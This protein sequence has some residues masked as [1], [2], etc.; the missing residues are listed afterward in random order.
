MDDSTR[1]TYFEHY[2]PLKFGSALF[3]KL[4][5]KHKKYWKLPHVAG[6]P[7]VFAVQD[8]HA[9]QAMSWSSSSLVEYLY[10]IRQVEKRRDDGSSEIVSEPIESY[11]KD[12]GREIPA[13]FFLQPDAE[14]ISAILANPEGTISKFNRMGFLAGFG[15]LGIRM[16]RNGT[17]YRDSLIPQDFAH[18]VHSPEYFE[19]WCEGL[20][21]YHNPRANYPLSPDSIPGAAHHF[22]RDGRILSRLPQFHP[23]GSLTAIVPPTKP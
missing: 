17:C 5:R 9:P 21:V 20:S 6:Y 8:F 11:R 19:T 22:N 18:E 3:S 12:D 15:D 16:F 13:G 1:Q 23:I 14:H 7:L 2:V 4:T 10:G